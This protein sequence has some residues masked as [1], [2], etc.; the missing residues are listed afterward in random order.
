MKYFLAS[1]S[2]IGSVCSHSLFSSLAQG[3]Q[4]WLFSAGPYTAVIAVAKW[5]I[6]GWADGATQLHWRECNIWAGVGSSLSHS[7]KHPLQGQEGLPALVVPAWLQTQELQPLC[8]S[9]QRSCCPGSLHLQ[10]ETALEAS[11]R[12]TPNPPCQPE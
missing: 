8:G 9:R 1:C 3:S 11:R 4:Q 2:A 10:A 6:L 5:K 7:S 12:G